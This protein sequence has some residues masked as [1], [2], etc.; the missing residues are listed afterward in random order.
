MQPLAGNPLTVYFLYFFRIKGLLKRHRHTVWRLF[1]HDRELSTLAIS[2]NK[3]NTLKDWLTLGHTEMRALSPRKKWVLLPSYKYYKTIIHHS[4]Y[5]FMVGGRNK[6]KRHTKIL[7]RC[8]SVIIRYIDRRLSDDCI[9]IIHATIQWLRLAFFE[10]KKKKSGT[11]AGQN[12]Q[13]KEKG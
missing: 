1:L 6:H 8:N 2:T 9:R 5:E 4:I 10:G 11:G 7:L 12:D 13:T 3:R